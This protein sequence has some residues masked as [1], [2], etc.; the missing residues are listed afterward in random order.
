VRF[1]LTSHLRELYLDPILDQQ[2]QFNLAIQA[3]I[4][5]LTQLIWRQAQQ[6]TARALHE[7]QA[8]IAELRA[9][10]AELEAQLAN[11]VPETSGQDDGIS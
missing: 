5:E 11:Q 2:E 7:Q 1:H 10:V 3:Q 9:R 6:D 8:Q 4:A